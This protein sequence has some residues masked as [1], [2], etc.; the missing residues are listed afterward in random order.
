M[1]PEGSRIMTKRFARTA[2]DSAVELCALA[3]LT[4][5]ALVGVL[6]L[7]VLVSVI[8]ISIISL[9]AIIIIAKGRPGVVQ[10]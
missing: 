9:I 3:S 5:A 2:V 8:L 10:Q 1:Q 4:V 7:G 6:S